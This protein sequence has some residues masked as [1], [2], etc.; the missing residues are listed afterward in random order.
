[1]FKS[2]FHGIRRTSL[3]Q[4]PL[5]VSGR[6]RSFIKEFHSSSPRFGLL[7][8]LNPLLTADLL[9]A[10]RLAG[11]G[12]EIAVVDCNFP[13][14]SIASE[15]IAGEVIQLPGVDSVSA[16]DAI[17][18][19]CPL[20]F[21]EE[22]PVLYMYPSEGLEYPDLAKEVHE[23][24]NAAIEAHAPGV[25]IQPLERFAFYDRTKT[26]FAIVQ[27][28]GE[29]RPYGNWILKKGVVGPD[30]NDLKP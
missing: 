23:K 7:K 8:N 29:R 11:H 24:G 19:V 26:A 1:M 3:C 18:S 5:L 21:F 16:V 4:F 2:V 15:T 25:A 30:G 10:L 27:A 12:D 28:G 13:A 17:C 20:D 14:Q 22:C 9:H 6:K